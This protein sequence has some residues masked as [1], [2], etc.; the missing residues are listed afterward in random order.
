MPPE[1]R[2]QPLDRRVRVPVVRLEE[3]EDQLIRTRIRQ[4]PP[5]G[6]VLGVRRGVEPD[7]LVQLAQ[8][9]RVLRQ[10]QLAQH[11]L[12]G[13]QGVRGPPERRERTRPAADG[14]VVLG[15]GA[16]RRLEP[17]QRLRRL[18][19]LPREL[20]HAVLIGGLFGGGVRERGGVHDRRGRVLAPAAVPVDLGGTRHDRRVV[21]Q[22][23]ELLQGLVGRL[24]V[25]ETVIRVDQHGVE[26]PAPRLLHHRQL[27]PLL[28][29]PVVVP[30]V[31]QG[32][33]P[34]QRLDVA[35][36]GGARGQ[37]TVQRLL[38]L[39]VE[40]AVGG[41]LPVLD[42][43]AAEHRPG[44]LVPG[45]LRQ[46]GLAVGDQRTE[47]GQRGRRPRAHRLHRPADGAGHGLGAVVHD[48]REREHG[49][50]QDDRA[51]DRRDQGPAQGMGAVA[52]GRG[53]AASRGDRLP[54]DRLRGE[55]LRGPG[56]GRLGPGPRAERP[57]VRRGPPVLGLPLRP[58]SRGPFR[59]LSRPL[60]ER[61][62]P[63][64]ARSLTFLFV[65]HGATVRP[66][67]EHTD[68]RQAVERT[69]SHRWPR[70]PVWGS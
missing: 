7:R 23:L 21:V 1:L 33:H 47:I 35:L 15:V 12:V 10:G 52:P 4:L 44:L 50:G 11:V 66:Y 40:P 29:G 20:A 37:R 48:E 18:T 45:V 34:G 19:A 28:R 62:R 67:E 64:G 69:G 3:T 8:L 17:A 39:R 61:R 16:Q 31:R 9:H 2:G 38:G 60:P 68:V 5:Y 70:V 43:G 41:P 63:I 32:G 46:V 6:V 36:V 55:R 53:A 54:G 49:A 25:A 59:S 14:G 30:G 58:G 51:D 56:P 22:L 13:R 26:V 65:R 42:V 27:A 57:R 24:V